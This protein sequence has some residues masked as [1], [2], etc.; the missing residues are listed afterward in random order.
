MEI[1]KFDLQPNPRV[2]SAESS[3]DELYIS[4]KIGNGQ[5][6][7]NKVTHNGELLA[8]GN[9]T[10]HTHIGSLSSLSGEE[11]EIETNVLDVNT[12]TNR[13][14]ITTIFLNQNNKELYSKIDKGN[15]PESGVASFRGKYLIKFILALICLI[16]FDDQSLFAQASSKE[17]E[18]NKLET[19]SS[20]GL[21][22]Y[23]Q[24][25]SSIEKPTTPQGLGISLL[26]LRQNGGA[27]EFAPFWLTDH[28]N[29]SAKDMY[30]NKTPVLSHLS[31]SIAAGKSD[32]LSFISGGI[33]TR[34]FQSYGKNVKYLDLYRS[35]LEELLSDL[36]ENK[37]KIDSL[38]EAYVKYTQ[39][40]I[41]SI[42]LAVALGGSSTINSYDSLDLNRWAMWL[43]FN[44]RPKGDDFYTTLV[45]RYINSVDY[46]Q[47][48]SEA[49]LVDLG[50]RLNY[51]ISK[52]TV[53]LEYIQRMNFTSERFDD[54]RLAVIGS[55]QLT[56]SIFITST[57]GKNFS[58]VNNIIALAGVNFGY[59]RK[60]VKSY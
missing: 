32:T 20:P 42:D 51:D 46:N 2:V 43:T 49:D 6:G 13:C 22:L 28:P 35:Q 29:L 56:D 9:L 17:I 23:D 10:E 48:S 37:E 16:P 34:L 19:P 8:K 54:Y 26:G 12:F 30:T 14:V 7:G 1:K 41:I 47:K 44:W 5:V 33:R 58:D 27:L 57:F 39:A 24:T 60:K 55:Y 38:R 21:I 59:S 11:I 52:V 36:P 18:F 4:I 3:S 50:A 15:A 40:P 25:S 45:A 53:S 31:V